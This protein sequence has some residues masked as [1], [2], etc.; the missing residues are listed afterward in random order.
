MLQPPPPTRS[1]SGTTCSVV[2]NVYDL[3]GT[4]L[5]TLITRAI[6]DGAVIYPIQDEL[7]IAAK[8]SLQALF[9]TLALNAGWRAHRIS[10]T[11]MLLEGE[12]I[13]V[14]V[15]GSHKPR[16]CSARFDIWTGSTDQAN[17]A[18]TRIL[19]CAAH[20]LIREPLISVDWMFANGSG[21]LHSATIEE[22]ADD[23]LDDE[24][25]PDIK[26]GVTRFVGN[27]L[28]SPE[29]I[30]VLQGP[31]GTGKTRLI[32]GILGEMSRRSAGKARVLY[33]GDA[34]ALERDEV[35]VKF[36]TGAHDAFV[37]EDADHILV[38]R[39][40]GNQH[41]HR[42]LSVADGIVRTHGRKIIFSTNL[43]NIGDLDDALVRPG[44]CYQRV[45]TRRLTTGEAQSLLDVLVRRGNAAG[46]PNATR[47]RPRIGAEAYS[48]AEVFRAARAT[49][50]ER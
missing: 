40:S 31:P 13:F 5:H 33:T 49:P 10:T 4:I 38:P 8:G 20:L 15:T 27:Y 19:E 9:D 50:E 39:T 25:Y 43:P 41:I 22:Q 17:R 3:P 42:F 32:R 47:V 46:A 6:E 45:W 23:I 36:A 2:D 14:S 7:R 37:V 12:S 28:D 16:Y 48:L 1:P 35:F 34:H 24:S 26:G 11:E 18:R 30:L 44:R 21:E 29:P